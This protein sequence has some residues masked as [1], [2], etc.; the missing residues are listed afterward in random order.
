MTVF[1]LPERTPNG[2]LNTPAFD[3]DGILW[4]T[5]Q[6]GIYGRV[7]PQSGEVG[8]LGIARADAGPYGITGT[9]DGGIYYASLAGNHIAHI[10]IHDG[11]GN[12]HRTAH[13]RAGRAARLVRFRRG[14]SGSANGTWGNVSV[15]DPSDESWQTWRLPGR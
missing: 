10:D 12:A 4:F 2:N 8:S 14:A 5:G 7:D 9:P 6:N 3:G 11:R 15:Y 1:P 13:R